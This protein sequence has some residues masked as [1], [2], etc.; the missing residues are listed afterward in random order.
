MYT[1][2]K[3]THER[4]A[5]KR[6]IDEQKTADAEAAALAFDQIDEAK[7]GALNRDQVK[8]LLKLVVGDDVAVDDM[9]VGLI[10]NAALA[11][12]E[13]VKQSQPPAPAP[14]APS[15]GIK[16]K[17]K[18][19]AVA[20]RKEQ[21]RAEVAASSGAAVVVPKMPRAALLRAATKYRYYLQHA[22]QLDAMFDRFD[23]N[24][25]GMLSRSELQRA[26]N[27]AERNNLRVNDDGVM[28][29]GTKRVTNMGGGVQLR[30]SDDD[31][32]YILRECDIN[33][34]GGIDK[35]ELLAALATWKLLTDQE[36]AERN[37]PCCVVL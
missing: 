15:P 22:K 16:Q 12:V 37:A 32:D 6:Q 11:H 19:S 28:Q 34:D 8:N 25:N 4:I 29:K 24:R 30:C 20:A 14:A 10:W 2:T 33:G 17:K 5:K 26:L 9:G 35:T 1:T 23:R 13:Q 21:Q 18:P 27:D 3:L 36:M 7:A 31:L